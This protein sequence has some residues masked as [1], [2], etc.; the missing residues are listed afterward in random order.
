MTTGVWKTLMVICGVFAALAIL[1]TGILVMEVKSLRE[2]A[3]SI[4]SEV[5]AMSGELSNFRNEMQ[6]N[7]NVV[8]EL[9]LTRAELEQARAELE[10]TNGRFHHSKDIREL[11]AIP[12]G[13]D[14]SMESV[15]ALFEECLEERMGLMGALY[16]VDMVDYWQHD[17]WQDLSEAGRIAELIDT[18]QIHGCWD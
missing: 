10:Q 13:K 3:D 9:E 11:A 16:A 8:A 18:G 7:V 17:Y 2:A 4:K 14:L 12:N 5:K 15:Q 1:T 6:D